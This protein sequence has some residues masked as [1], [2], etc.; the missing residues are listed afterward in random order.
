MANVYITYFQPER[1]TE[2]AVLCSELGWLPKSQIT[3][4]NFP[5]ENSAYVYVA[6]PVW[7]KRKT[8]GASDYMYGR[9]AFWLMDADE[10]H[11]SKYVEVGVSEWL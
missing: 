7:L 5:E 6:M 8:V 4:F 2:K 10:L 1:V 3:V 11:S 9:R